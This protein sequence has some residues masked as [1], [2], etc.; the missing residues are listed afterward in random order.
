MQI[1]SMC[2]SIGCGT[3]EVGKWIR[4]GAIEDDVGKSGFGV[5]AAPAT[6]GKLRFGLKAAPAATLCGSEITRTFVGGGAV[7][8]T[9]MTPGPGLYFADAGTVKRTGG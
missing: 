8:R 3:D 7:D 4:A 9:R 2:D 6:T 1:N 5:K